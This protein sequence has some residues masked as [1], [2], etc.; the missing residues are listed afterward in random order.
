[1][2]PT[3]E[4]RRLI[5]QAS[6][7]NREAL[8]KAADRRQT[9]DGPNE[10]RRAQ[11][12]GEE[13]SDRR[14]RQGRR[15]A[16]A[17]DPTTP[18]PGLALDRTRKGVAV[19]VPKAGPGG[20]TV[21]RS[22]PDSQG[23]SAAAA[24]APVDEEEYSSAPDVVGQI[25]DDRYRVEHLLGEGG[26]GRVYLAE[27]V[28]IGK[29][30][31]VKVLHPV[32]SRMPDLVERF[33]R[34][35]RAATKIGHPN[36]VD[37]TDSGTTA[38]GSV[39]FVMEYLEGVELA[40]VIDREGAID[41]RRALSIAAQICRALNAAHASGIIHR[42]L[43]PENVFLTSREGT[44]D[45]VKVLDF[46][47][48]KSSEAEEA[49]EKKLTHPGMAMGT[50]EYMAPEQAAGKTADE[51][52]DVYAV[53]AILYEMLTGSPPYEGENFM[54]ILTKKAT[55]EPTP[56]RQLRP[57]IPE[58]VEELVQRAMGRSPDERPASMEAFEY[59]LTKCA[60]GRS[61]A[62]ANILGISHDA[63]D[64]GPGG[65][66][67]GLG[68]GSRSGTSE[69]GE[70]S[71]SGQ[72]SAE[73]G[74]PVAGDSGARI[75]SPQS[76]VPSDSFETHTEI[77]PDVSS[78][79]LRAL[80]WTL[81]VLVLVACGAAV[82][83][84][85]KGESTAPKPAA[86]D[87]V[88]SEGANPGG[89]SPSA[90]TDDSKQSHEGAAKQPRHEASEKLPATD[91]DGNKGS[92]A[93]ASDDKPAKGDS[94]SGRPAAASKPRRSGPP[95]NDK[96]AAHLLAE[97]RGHVAN[98]EWNEANALYRRV[99]SGKFRRQQGFLG[100]ADVAFQNKQADQAI[101]FAKKAGNSIAAKMVRGNA[102]FKK[103]DY[104]SALKMYN[105]VLAR[106]PRHKEAQRSAKAARA[107][108]GK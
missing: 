65:G 38:D 76:W 34:E 88:D 104:K 4:L 27:H 86:G 89:D 66:M 21:I 87:V 36:I 94:N 14:M 71:S 43:K 37:V 35:A 16:D 81:F 100:L 47:I 67:I 60:S 45:F 68:D 58:I 106:A 92:E 20:S 32:Y 78:G 107:K 15:L 5:E 56:P 9:E 98:M 29:R 1:L 83:Y 25:L 77:I 31:A 95:R 108:L 19:E 79:G 61:A 69:K 2:P 12:R 54:E 6:D 22:S 44:S 82:F 10:G 99:V 57:E 73:P 80:G 7:V 90:T 62:V 85:A 91:G 55:L 75:K 102:Y 48:A 46:G 52:C 17:L 96:E 53:G 33:R 30:V 49:R 70:R 23:A 42:D 59:E 11:D 50:P 93:A 97:A 51:R 24:K 3:D 101:Q 8:E 64:S 13:S 40:G 18:M 72:M 84:V 105:E 28:D 26:M 63:D 41:V 74:P 103:G 39:Y